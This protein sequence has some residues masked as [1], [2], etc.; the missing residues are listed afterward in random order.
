MDGSHS[1]S[2]QIPIKEVHTFFTH[3]AM[4]ARV[5]IPPRSTT[6]RT[7]ARTEALVRNIGPNL[8]AL[9][10]CLD[11]RHDLDHFDER[12]DAVLEYPGG[13]FTEGTIIAQTEESLGKMLAGRTVLP[14]FIFLSKDRAIVTWSSR[15]Q[16]RITPLDPIRRELER[17]A[18]WHL[19]VLEAR[20]RRDQEA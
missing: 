8:H 13:R 14:M 20:R 11:A 19:R 3:S 6:A 12:M 15:G 17:L 1:Q 4:V 2:W 10:G 7:R 9:Q 5:F 18:G 16:R